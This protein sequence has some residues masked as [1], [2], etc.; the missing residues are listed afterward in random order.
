MRQLKY[1]SQYFVV[2]LIIYFT[3]YIYSIAQFSSIC[4]T[5][6][7]VCLTSSPSIC[8]MV[9]IQLFTDSTCISDKIESDTSSYD[10]SSHYTVYLVYCNPLSMIR[11]K[12]VTYYYQNNP[13]SQVGF[14]IM[15]QS[16][17]L[18]E[19]EVYRRCFYISAST[20]TGS[21]IGQQVLFQQSVLQQR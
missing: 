6:Y 21:W 9:P 1:I 5:V 18:I 12:T 10:I 20:L 17:D 3:Y 13:L 7:R 4:M 11:I 2:C 15:S 19:I 8:T 16:D 14:Q